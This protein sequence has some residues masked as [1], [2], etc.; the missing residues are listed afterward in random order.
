MRESLLILVGSVGLVLLVF[1]GME[2]IL[3][4]FSKP[5]RRCRCC[6]LI[7]IRAGAE[8]LEQLL[9][10]GYNSV[11]WDRWIMSGRLILV[12][13]GADEESRKICEAFCEDRKDVWFL[14]PEQLSEAVGG[15]EICKTVRCVLY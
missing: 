11:L 6:L 2:L 3:P 12:D 15:E 7:P 14:R 1:A 8:D 13:L 10:W 9:R 5:K 4:V